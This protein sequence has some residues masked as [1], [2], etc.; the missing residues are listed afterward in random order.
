VTSSH[1]PLRFPAA[2]T[3]MVAVL[4]RRFRDRRIRWLVPHSRSSQLSTV[5][6]K[7]LQLYN[8]HEAWTLNPSLNP[9]LPPVPSDFKP[10][11]QISHHL[12]RC[13][14]PS[15]VCLLNKKTHSPPHCLGLTRRLSL[16]PGMVD[17][18][19]DGMGTHAASVKQLATPSSGSDRG[20]GCRVRQW[21]P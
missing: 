3:I 17:A 2:V 16:P 9:S 10:T 8:S 1:T 20:I 21:H 5:Q 13:P 4:P 14:S 6:R 7:S 18:G 12:I 15:P 19:S 11:H